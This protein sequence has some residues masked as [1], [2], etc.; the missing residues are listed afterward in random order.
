MQS[1]KCADLSPEQRS[2]NWPKLRRG[3]RSFRPSLSPSLFSY[4]LLG[5]WSHPQAPRSHSALGPYHEHNREREW[6]REQNGNGEKNGN[7][8]DFLPR[9]HTVQAPFTPRSRSKSF[10]DVYCIY[11]KELKC[12]PSALIFGR[13]RAKELL[14]V[15]DDLRKCTR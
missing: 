8:I 14:H 13:G 15:R 9:S 12:K 6:K 3:W 7:G 10:F 11:I 2:V 5:A 4:C 1:A